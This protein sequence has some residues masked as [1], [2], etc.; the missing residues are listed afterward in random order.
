MLTALCSPDAVV[1]H[2][3]SFTVTPGQKVGI[4][5]RTGSGKSSLVATILRLLEMEAGSILVDGQD[6]ARL[7]RS[8]VRQRLVTLPQD[9]L[10]L[11]GTARANAD[12]YG[13]CSDADVEA[14]LRR[15]GLWGPALEQRGGLD[16]EVS[17]SSLSK[18]EQQLLALARAVLEVRTRRKRVVLLDEPTSNIDDATSATVQAVVLDEFA[19][20]T[21]LTVA[22]RIETIAGC[23]LVLVLD[24]GRLVEAGPPDD[25]TRAGGRFASLVAGHDARNGGA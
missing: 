4:C 12:P 7:P 6:L 13:L 24:E 3:I 1:L 5:G 8:T 18:G 22:H 11:I 16:A 10:I 2:D 25:L 20:C 9:P 23:D 14:A 19:A 17:T 15:V 21:V